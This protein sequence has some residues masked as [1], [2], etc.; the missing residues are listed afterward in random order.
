MTTS[1]EQDINPLEM[2]DADVLNL[3]PNTL[4]DEPEDVVPQ[5]DED[6]SPQDVEGTESDGS[7]EPEKADNSQEEDTQEE[8]TE[9][10]YKAF[11]AAI[12]APF[13]ANGTMIS[14]ET[15]AEA[16]SLMQKGVSY[17]KNMQDLKPSRALLK[18]LEQH[19]LL[20]EEKVGFLIDVYN[21]DPSAMA[22]L[23]KDSEV[24]LYDI[25]SQ[26][27]ADSY[28]AI[29]KAPDESTLTLDDTLAELQG[30]VGYAEVISDVGNAFDEAS[31]SHIAANPH[32][33]RDLVGHAQSGIYK[34]IMDYIKRERAFGRLQVPDL[35]A[36]QIAGNALQAQGKL[37]QA[38]P[39]IPVKNR[40]KPADTSLDQRRKSLAVSGSKGSSSKSIKTDFLAMSDEEFAKQGLPKV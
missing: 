12:T 35:H 10:D 16:I 24:D 33:L 39:T 15:P 27:K 7:S 2:S 38:N 32:I 5:Q 36:Y 4:V 20:S 13:K 17:S 31:R 29:A 30:E 37:N 28:K 11:Y 14:V 6:D 34:V 18:M 26:E 9:I 8:D 40:N 3:D 21:K 23:F 25:D 19:G 22:K 1:K